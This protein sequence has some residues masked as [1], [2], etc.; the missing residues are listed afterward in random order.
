MNLSKAIDNVTRN[1]LLLA[2]GLA[3]VGVAA[4]A[5]VRKTITDAASAGAGLVSGDNAI[6]E[7]ARTT[8]YRGTGVVGT[9]GAAVDIAS[10]GTL[11]KVGEEI[12]S[13]FVPASNGP[14]LTYAVRFPNGAMGAV[15]SESI[16]RN[17][18]FTY[19]GTSAGYPKGTRFRIGIDKAG[20][21]TAVLV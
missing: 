8:A 1:P 9:L 13:W 21:R 15:N 10:G 5:L 16:D 18:Y 7:A 19:E 20:Q 12:S 17:G 2:A 6:T 4:Y 11:S 14:S 3:L